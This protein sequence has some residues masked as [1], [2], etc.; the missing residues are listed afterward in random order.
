VVRGGSFMYYEELLE[1]TNRGYYE[2]QG[3]TFDL[4]FRI[5]RPAP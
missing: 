5:S 1:V 3:R 4:G 2:P